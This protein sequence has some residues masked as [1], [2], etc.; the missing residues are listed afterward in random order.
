MAN[1]PILV[2]VENASVASITT[3]FFVLPDRKRNN[4]KMIKTTLSKG[5]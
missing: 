2:Y 4:N 1:L 3:L 5:N